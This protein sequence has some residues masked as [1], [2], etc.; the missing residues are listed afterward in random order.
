MN[1]KII[2]FLEEEENKYM[3]GR[4]AYLSRSCVSVSHIGLSSS[5]Y[6]VST[7]LWPV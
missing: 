2:K 7:T 6:N 1:N 3:P 4:R 5:L